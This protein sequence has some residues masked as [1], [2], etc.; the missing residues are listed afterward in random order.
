ME[1]A[2]RLTIGDG[3]DVLALQQG[4]GFLDDEGQV[5]VVG[6]GWCDRHAFGVAHRIPPI[7]DALLLLGLGQNEH[8]VE[9]H[10]HPICRQDSSTQ[11]LV[12]SAKMA[13]AMATH[14]RVEGYLGWLG[15]VAFLPCPP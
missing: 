4:F 6:V 2:G 14:K 10:Q 13:N 12:V 9:Q 5:I 8:V 11:G 15:R 7:L 1:L 3:D